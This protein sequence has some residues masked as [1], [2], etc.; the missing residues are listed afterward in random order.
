MLELVR[1]PRNVMKG[2]GHNLN[3]FDSTHELVVL[4]NVCKR[5]VANWHEQTKLVLVANFLQ[6]F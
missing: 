5:A 3:L 1:V 4:Q 6:V 2:Y